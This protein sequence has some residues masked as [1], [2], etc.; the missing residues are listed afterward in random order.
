MNPNSNQQPPSRNILL[1]NTISAPIY[2]PNAPNYYTLS[3]HPLSMQ[4]I[5]LAAANAEGKG[6]WSTH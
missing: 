1:S 4:Q 3:Y 6:K 2:S 5:M